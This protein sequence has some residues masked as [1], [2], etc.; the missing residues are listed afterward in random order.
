MA[1]VCGLAWS[2]LDGAGLCCPGRW[3]PSAR[4]SDQVSEKALLSLSNLLQA[5]FD[6]RRLVMELA[7]GKHKA[8]PF[9]KELLA[10]GRSALGTCITLAEDEDPE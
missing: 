5:E 1:I 3:H 7:A 9:S 2:D 8:S 6:M 10:R 4:Q